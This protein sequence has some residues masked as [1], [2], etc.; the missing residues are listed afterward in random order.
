[1]E[2]EPKIREIE[3]VEKKTVYNFGAKESYETENEARY[4]L[5]KIA[6]EAHFL[7][8]YK[9]KEIEVTRVHLKALKILKIDYN[10]NKD[11]RTHSISQVFELNAIRNICFALGYAFISPTQIPNEIHLKAVRIHVE[12]YCC[13]K[14]LCQNLG[15]QEGTYQ[16]DSST[17]TWTKK[18]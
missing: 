9:K 3:I 12:L 5:G 1:M 4:E 2:Q 17:D 16:Y 6:S 14:I 7:G 15:I 8:I 11:E 18:Q 10:F 13:M